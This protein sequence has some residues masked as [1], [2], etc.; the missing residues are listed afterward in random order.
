MGEVSDNTEFYLILLSVHCAGALRRVTWLRSRPSFL[1]PTNSDKR[2]TSPRLTAASRG[3]ATSSQWSPSSTLVR[4]PPLPGA[5]SQFSSCVHYTCPLH[6][7]SL[8]FIFRPERKC[9]SPVGFHAPG[10]EAHL[11]DEPG[12]HGE[13]APQGQQTLEFVAACQLQEIGS[14]LK[15][16]HTTDCR[17]IG[18]YID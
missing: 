7:S 9:S 10:A 15:P 13:T 11:P 1:T 8:T 14:R 18:L 12:H 2:R 5:A 6:V 16:S 3:A 17:S 4:T